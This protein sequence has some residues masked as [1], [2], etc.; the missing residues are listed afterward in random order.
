MGALLAAS[1]LYHGVG[2]V[3]KPEQTKGFGL[4]LVSAMIVVFSSGVIHAIAGAV[5]RGKIW[6]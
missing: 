3:L 4:Y 1:I 2:L 5:L 6:R